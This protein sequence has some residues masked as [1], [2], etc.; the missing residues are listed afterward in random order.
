[1]FCPSGRTT[2]FGTINQTRKSAACAA[3]P[4]ESVVLEL[5]RI[6]CR[7]GEGVI[8]ACP[9][10]PEVRSPG[11]GSCSRCGMALEPLMAGAALE[12]ADATQHQAE[13]GLHFF[14][15]PWACQSRREHAIRSGLLLSPMIAGVVM[16]LS[17]ISVVANA[18]RLRQARIELTFDRVPAKLLRRFMPGS[19]SPANPTC[20]SL[21]TLMRP[22]LANA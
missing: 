21:G 1:V 7:S 9:M 15:T 22:A 6:S 2:R 17:S 5:R 10:H 19:C 18:L 14:I 16:R 3:M 12:R 20:G 11:P 8:H 13:P 4:S